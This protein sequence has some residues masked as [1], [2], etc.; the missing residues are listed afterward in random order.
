MRNKV[1]IDTNVLV[2][3]ADRRSSHYVE[4]IELLTND[5]YD[6][7]VSTKSVSEFYSVMTRSTTPK[8]SV[9]DA[10]AAMGDILRI[11]NILYPSERSINALNTLISKYQPKGLRIFDFEIISVALA[12]DITH[13]ATFNYKDFDRIEEVHTVTR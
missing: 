6:F 10:Q 2:Y 11:Y 13:I 1:L 4:A 7:Y 8:L 12:N 5:D 3:S 9:E